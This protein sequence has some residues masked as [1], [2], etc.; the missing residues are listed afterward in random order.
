MALVA[1]LSARES[2]RVRP[3][4]PLI[5]FGGQPLVEFQAR[6]ALEAGADGLLILA[7]APATDL[8][9]LIDRLATEHGRP[10]A[11]VQDQLSLSRALVPEDRVLILA[12]NLV[13]PPE[14]LETLL[15]RGP[16]ALLSLPDAPST[17]RF[18]RL[19]P[20]ANWGGAMLLPAG[21]ILA[22][23]DMLGDWDL[24]LTLLRRAVQAG[25][26][27]VELSPELVMDGRLTLAS[28]QASADLALDALS[29]QRH[30]AAG[31]LN[32][33]LGSLFSPLSR[34]LVRE[35]V[36][37]QVDPGTLGIASLV[38]AA[39]GLALA[40]SAWMLTALSVMLLA[41]ST[42]D[43][44]RQTAEVTLRPERSPLRR[45]VVEGAALL[46]LALL[47]FHLAQ[48]SLLA[49]AG[50]WGPL[51][52]IGLLALA[53]ERHPPEGLWTRLRL[54]TPV[55]LLVMLIGQLFGLGSAAFALLG[56]IACG[57]IGLRLLK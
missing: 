10:I 33:G 13:V 55:A 46:V 56:L 44:A 11:L 3:G 37:R 21:N 12:E 25:I 6:L 36:R 27:R 30:A 45:R 17:S 34:S 26:P 7:D 19:D 49:M 5:D 53:D 29:D 1:L 51:V 52:L 40:T 28:D 57:M 43:L 23:L 16:P 14:A 2:A 15:E 38:F 48:G 31:E 32:S 42:S 24:Q 9:Q 18:E 22:T 41:V 35:M 39:A 20:Q 54:T 4:G 47:G 50:A 8:G